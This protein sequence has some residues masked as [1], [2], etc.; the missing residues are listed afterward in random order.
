M[1]A[2]FSERCDADTTAAGGAEEG[3]DAKVPSGFGV[4]RHDGAYFEL[5]LLRQLALQDG[6][7]SE[8]VVNAKIPPALPRFSSAT[9]LSRQRPSG[10][11]PRR[12]Q[13]F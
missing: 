6:L 5:H 7:E 9:E 1:P 8:I 10:S 11:E 2:R 3:V 13:H 12:E 4:S